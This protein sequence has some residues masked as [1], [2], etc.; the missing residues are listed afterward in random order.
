M[1]FPVVLSLLCEFS[2]IIQLL[3]AII[4]PSGKIGQSYGGETPVI[5]KEKAK[6]Q[7]LFPTKDY[8]YKPGKDFVVHNFN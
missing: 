6:D 4:F 1:L 2:F 7:V 5:G 3:Q 8:T